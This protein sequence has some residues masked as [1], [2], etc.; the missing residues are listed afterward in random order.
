LI[1]DFF[2]VSGVTLKFTEPLDAKKPD[3]NW[4]IFP[5][6]GDEELRKII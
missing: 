4:R 5:F 1:Y 6:R 2:E 3:E